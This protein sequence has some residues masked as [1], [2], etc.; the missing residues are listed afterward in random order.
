MGQYFADTAGRQDEW[1]AGRG[2]GI[3]E[4]ENNISV[5]WDE[6]KLQSK[7][8]E[9]G[10]KDTP[11]YT[12]LSLHRDVKINFGLR[13]KQHENSMF[14]KNFPETKGGRKQCT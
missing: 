3:L 11:L 8:L 2:L 7:L 4:E 14:T 10:W 1:T 6:I 12:P 9:D 5:R 13:L